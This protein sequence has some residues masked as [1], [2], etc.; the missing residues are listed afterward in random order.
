MKVKLSK[1][2]TRSS[3]KVFKLK[4]E[5][6]KN[7]NQYILKLIKEAHKIRFRSPRS[8]I[9]KLRK[10]V[11]LTSKMLKIKLSKW[12]TRSSEKV[13]KL[14]FKKFKNLDQDNRKLIKEEHKI[15]YRSPRS[16]IQSYESGSD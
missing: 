2:E 7:S 15:R 5:K 3:E 1:W 9:K 16:R 4:F 6:F 12:E 13:F 14:K 11:C 10:W 8:R